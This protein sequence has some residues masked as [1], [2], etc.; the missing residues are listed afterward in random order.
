MDLEEGQLWWPKK[1]LCLQ[2]NSG[3]LI[4]WLIVKHLETRKSGR[5]NSPMTGKLSESFQQESSLGP[6]DCAAGGVGGLPASIYPASVCVFFCS[7]VTWL[8][9][10]ACWSGCC[11]LVSTQPSGPPFLLLQ[12]WKGRSV[13]LTVNGLS[14]SRDS[15]A[16]LCLVF[17]CLMTT[18]NFWRGWYCLQPSQCIRR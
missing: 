6:R 5:S 10:E 8:S 9:G 12:I 16:L 3:P 17:R 2:G 11:F 1:H 15:D 4:T 14:V 18:T 7:S 13:L